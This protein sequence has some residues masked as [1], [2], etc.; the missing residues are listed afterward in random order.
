M[1]NFYRDNNDIQF[2][3]RHTDLRKSVETREEDFRF[4]SEFDYAPANAEEC[5]GGDTEL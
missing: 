1:A 2:L 4:A 5:R 3:F